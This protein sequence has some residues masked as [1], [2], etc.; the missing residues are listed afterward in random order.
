MENN[1]IKLPENQGLYDCLVD[2]RSILIK[3]FRHELSMVNEAVLITCDDVF[4]L[5]DTLN[6]YSSNLRALNSLCSQIPCHPSNEDINS[7]RFV[8]FD[9]DEKLT[10]DDMRL[11][12]Q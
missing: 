11:V 9:V 5:M 12:S 10:C 7:S 4:K 6:F 1:K 3:Y 8:D 2:Q